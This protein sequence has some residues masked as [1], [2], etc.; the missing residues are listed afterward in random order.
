MPAPTPSV[1]ADR[2][3]DLHDL[4]ILD[5]PPPPAVQRLVELARDLLDAPIAA[6]SLIDADREQLLARTGPVPRERPRMAALTLHALESAAAHVAPDALA[7]P[8]LRDHPL[9]DGPPGVRFYAGAPILLPSGSAIGALVVMDTRPRTPTE[10]DIRRLETLARLVRDVLDMRRSILIARELAGEAAAEESPRH[11]DGRRFARISHDMRTPLGHILGFAELLQ[12][13]GRPPA[14]AEEHADY[15]DIIRSSGEE[16]MRLLDGAIEDERRRSRGPGAGEPIDLGALLRDIVRT[17]AG[18]AAAHGQHLAL[19]D[20]TDGKE[21]C[22]ARVD[23]VALR[24]V[25]NNLIANAC[26][27]AGDGARIDVVLSEPDDRGGPMVEVLDDGPGVPDRVLARLGRPFVQGVKDGQTEPQ[28]GAGLG[29]SNV[30]EI[31]D[32]NGWDFALTRRP[33]GGA[34]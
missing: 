2:L 13:D 29:L 16:L 14:A 33:S 11:A 24:R 8:R 34:A 27:H 5:R 25:V 9:V 7:D 26:A 4:H 3:A 12:G 22:R 32:A 21:P 20:A 30:V 18:D 31:A 17:F 10:Q 28:G 1:E 19:A 6:V 23:A 15:L